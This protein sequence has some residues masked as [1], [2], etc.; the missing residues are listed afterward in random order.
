[1][2]T[3][4]VLLSDVGGTNAR[5]ELRRIGVAP[6]GSDELVHTATYPTVGPGAQQ[7]SGSAMEALVSRF[8]GECQADA[9]PDQCVLAVCGPVVDGSAYCASQVTLDGLLLAP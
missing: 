3:K 6:S 9:Q 8:L 1:M 5:F 4:H 2:A 7:G